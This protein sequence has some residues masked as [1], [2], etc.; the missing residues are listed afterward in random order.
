MS[1]NHNP[2]WKS[3]ELRVLER[4]I[5][6]ETALKALMMTEK[7]IVLKNRNSWIPDVFRTRNTDKAFRQR[8]QKRS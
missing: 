2:S 7:G 6:L 1:K 8:L 3:P 4:N 5:S